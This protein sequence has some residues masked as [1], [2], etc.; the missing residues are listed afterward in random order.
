MSSCDGG[1]TAKGQS[2]RVQRLYCE[3]RLREELSGF[4]A[5][6][7]FEHLMAGICLA[8]QVHTRPPVLFLHADSLN[9]TLVKSTLLYSN[10]SI[11]RWVEAKREEKEDDED[12]DEDE[13]KDEDK[14]KD[15]K[16]K[17]KEKEKEEETPSS[18]EHFSRAINSRSNGP[19]ALTR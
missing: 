4:T 11:G 7:M 2:T 5:S 18:I 3:G 16:E 17:E 15:E 13:D 10:L 9:S 6:A 8:R 14:D 19:L 12:E 1:S